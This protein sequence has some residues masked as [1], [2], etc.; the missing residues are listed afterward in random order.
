MEGKN[1]RK[2]NLSQLLTPTITPMLAESIRK[3]YN[4]FVFALSDTH[5][6][7]TPP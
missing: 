2:L 4:S 7:S 6:S 3:S 1:E 5:P